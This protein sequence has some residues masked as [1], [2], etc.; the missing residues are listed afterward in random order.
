[1]ESLNIATIYLN[2]S[3]LTGCGIFND[4]SAP[5]AGYILGIDTVCGPTP[6][7]S[8]RQLACYIM[9]NVSNL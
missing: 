3:S 6:K 2:Y 9:A 1:M 5:K 4:V 7:V 8:L